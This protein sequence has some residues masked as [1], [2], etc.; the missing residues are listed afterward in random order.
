GEVGSLA[1]PAW[2][3]DLDVARDLA[4]GESTVEDRVVDPAPLR[5]VGAGV[6]RMEVRVLDASGAEL[7]R[8]PFF[9][10][11]AGNPLLTVA[12]A[13]AVAL[14][15]VSG[16]GLWRLLRDLL[17]LNQAAKRHCSRR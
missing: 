10:R 3:R 2:S 4:P 14:T 6:F 15:G 5:A 1:A 8:A 12:G 13:V 17:E 11:V 16:Y 7:A 9:V